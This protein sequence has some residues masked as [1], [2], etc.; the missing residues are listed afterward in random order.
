[1]EEERHAASDEPVAAAYF[2]AARCALGGQTARANAEGNAIRANV[3]EGSGVGEDSLHTCEV[4]LPAH[5][6]PVLTATVKLPPTVC[7]LVL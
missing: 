7:A 4:I 1:M 6:A 5:V 2:E 3:D